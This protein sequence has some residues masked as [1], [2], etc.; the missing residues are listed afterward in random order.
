MRTFLARIFLVLVVVLASPVVAFAA[1]NGETRDT[2]WEWF[3]RL[4][5]WAAGGWHG[6]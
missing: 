3:V 2:L 6:Y 4:V 1:D 5:T